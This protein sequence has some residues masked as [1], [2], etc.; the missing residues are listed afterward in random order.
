MIRKPRSCWSASSTTVCLSQPEESPSNRVR[1]LVVNVAILALFNAAASYAAA[2]K[3]SWPFEL[4]FQQIAQLL[5]VSDGT[6]VADVG[7]G[8]GEWTSRLAMRVGQQGHVFTT[9]VKGPQVQGLRQ[10]TRKLKN[11]TVVFGSQQ[12]AGLPANCC[13]AML[14]RLVYHAFTDPGVMRDG[15]REAMKT[16]GLVLVIDF[17][18]SAEQLTQ[19]MQEAGFE[20]VQLMER[21]YRDEL[22]AVLFRKVVP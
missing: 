17:D 16:G 15:I 9:E 12:D 21:W 5:K 8:S 4:E 3:Q 7:A 1:L 14:L 13:D 19:D 6:V 10:M 11:I 20:R 18:P 22:F 2:G